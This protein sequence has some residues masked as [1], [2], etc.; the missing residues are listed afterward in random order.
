MLVSPLPSSFLD[1]YCL[2]Q[3]ISQIWG[4]VHGHRFPSQFVWV[5]SLSI[6]RMFQSILQ[7]RLTRCLFLLIQFLPQN[8]GS[9]N[10][11]VHLRYSFLFFFFFFSFLFIWWC[12]LPIFPITSNFPFLPAFRFFLDLAVL[13][14]SLS[15]F[16]HFSLWALHIFLCQISF[17]YPGCIFLL[18]DQNIPFFFYFCK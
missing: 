18:L 12:P 17:L 4:L 1:A 15:I 14:L 2:S 10:V 6:L 11:H 5:P 7:G 13:F 16:S 9:K 8:L 3:S